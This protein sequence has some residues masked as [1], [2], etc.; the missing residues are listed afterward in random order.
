MRN[1]GFAE[2]ICKWCGKRYIFDEDDLELA[3][4]EKKSEGSRFN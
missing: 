2:V 3:L 1:E 4:M